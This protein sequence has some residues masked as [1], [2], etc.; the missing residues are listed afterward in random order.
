MVAWLWQLWLAMLLRC[1]GEA[2]APL[3]KLAHYD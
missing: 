1:E 3:K 2:A